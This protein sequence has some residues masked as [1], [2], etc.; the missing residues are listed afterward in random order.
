MHRMRARD[1]ECRVRS[2]QM[3]EMPVANTIPPSRTG[4]AASIVTVVTV[5]FKAASEPWAHCRCPSGP[6]HRGARIRS[7][8]HANRW[9][10]YRNRY[11][12]HLE[13]HRR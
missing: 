5:Y 8:R 12:R 6:T 3:A 9:R 11:D 13:Y 2:M 1:M 4:L 7:I 10:R